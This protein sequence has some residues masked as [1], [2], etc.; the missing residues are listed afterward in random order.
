MKYRNILFLIF[1]L[2]FTTFSWNAIAEPNSA[3]SLEKMLSA[4]IANDTEIQR[5]ALQYQQSLLSDNITQNNAAFNLNLS[6]GTVNIKPG[7][8]NANPTIEIS[9]PTLNGTSL[10][11][12][13]PISISS[14][15]SEP[16]AEGANISLQ[17]ELLGT[18]KK[19]Q[20][21][22]LLKSKRSVL[23]SQRALQNQL[24]NTEY[25][26]YNHLKNIY[27]EYASLLSSQ[28]T[29]YEEKIDL[30]AIVVQGYGTQSA[31]YRTA[32]LEMLNASHTVEE[33][34]RSLQRMI[35]R[36]AEKCSLQPEDLTPEN[37]PDV[38]K[39]LE[40]SSILNESITGT[41]LDYKAMDK[42][43]WNK[44][45]A[46]L[47]QELNTALKISTDF[48][49]TYK[50]SSFNDND[51]IDTSFSL[52]AF[53]AKLSAGIA[54]PITGEN[55]T[56]AGQISLSWSPNSFKEQKIKKEQGQINIQLANLDILQATEDYRTDL[57]E[58]ITTKEDLLWTR[59]LNIEE[60]NLY[61]ELVSDMQNWF[62]AG[63]ITDSENR[64][65]LVNYQKALIQC[66]I[67][68]IEL[69]LNSIKTKMLFI[70]EGEQ[71]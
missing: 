2:I 50:N 63:F 10:T 36:F 12:N 1:L 41:L 33:K 29:L 59:S 18:T 49:Y 37:L 67:T 51:T 3:E 7:S 24:K 64:Q 32:Q 25:D 4:F 22:S 62:N 52:S 68:D 5:L 55:K 53:G 34:K 9:L 38:T 13:I 21:L 8:F 60:A 48:G 47:E 27:S 54:M 61:R 56:P 71:K 35:E 17:T 57:E 26:F 20:E 11:T 39:I 69:L 28:N 43:L 6:T 31:K 15:N 66:K 42:A 30:E 70:D 16:V 58:S 14:I 46:E 44:N 19:Q 65:A 23:E 45:I 40:N